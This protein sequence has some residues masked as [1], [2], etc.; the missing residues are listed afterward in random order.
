VDYLTEDQMQ[1]ILELT[2]VPGSQVAMARDLFIFQMYTGLGYADTQI[3]DLSQYV[4]VDGKW[5]FIGKRVKTG[6]PYVSVLLAPVVDILERHGMSVPQ[7]PN[8]KYNSL[9]KTMGMVIGI[10]GLH[11]HLARHTFATY[12]LSN[13]VKVQNLMRMLGHKNIQQTMKYANVL[14]KDARNDFDMVSKKLNK[15]LTIKK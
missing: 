10:E 4:E 8:Q 5:R 6:V 14:A 1:K 11:S 15:K 3:F 9:L 7:M 12:M 2:P 13:D